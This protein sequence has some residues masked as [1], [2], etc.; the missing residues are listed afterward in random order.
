MPKQGLTLR[1]NPSIM[2][3]SEEDSLTKGVSILA[4][5][6][7]RYGFSL[8]EE[9]L[10]VVQELSRRHKRSLN[11]E[12]AWALEQFVRQE[13]PDLARRLDPQEPEREPEPGSLEAFKREM[14]EERRRKEE[15][16]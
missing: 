3:V 9:L 12:V 16:R 1:D 10:S 6:L 11:S 4:E 2:R 14:A 8:D 5:K 7:K 13:A 15:Q